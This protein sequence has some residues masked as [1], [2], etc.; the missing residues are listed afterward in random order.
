MPEPWR[1]SKDIACL[2]IVAPKY[3]KKRNVASSPVNPVEYLIC[4][5]KKLILIETII[6]G[7]FAS[8]HLDR[9]NK[10]LVI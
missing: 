6:N 9:H 5:Y 4:L 10:R 7:A 1:N 3:T 2:F 8:K